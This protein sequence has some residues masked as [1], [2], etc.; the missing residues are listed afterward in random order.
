MRTQPRPRR[1]ISPAKLAWLDPFVRYSASRDAYVLRIVGRHIGPV[2][3]MVE[4]GGRKL[5]DGTA[6]ASNIDGRADEL[7]GGE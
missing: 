2:F 7:S 4:G 3:R 5:G 6:Q 1:E